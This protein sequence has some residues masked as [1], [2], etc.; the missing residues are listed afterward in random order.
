MENEIILILAVI[1]IFIIWNIYNCKYK[2]EGFYPYGWRG[3]RW[4]RYRYPYAYP[5]Y[6]YYNPY[7]WW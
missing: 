1:I 5:Y 2:K 7:Y 4:W 6:Y 3:S